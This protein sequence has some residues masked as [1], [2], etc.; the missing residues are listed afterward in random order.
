MDYFDSELQGQIV[1]AGLVV[2]TGA[3]FLLRAV[4]FLRRES[5]GDR[6]LYPDSWKEDQRRTFE[7]IRSVIGLSLVPLWGAYLS[8]TPLTPRSWRFE[9]TLLM[10]MLLAS[11]AWTLLLAPRNS[12]Q[13]DA[14]PRSFFRMIAF[15]V[16]CCGTA[17]AAIGWMLTEVSARPSIHIIPPGVYAAGGMAPAHTDTGISDLATHI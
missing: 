10:L 2:L 7:Q 12:K 3:V 8:L 11:Y 5:V 4:I 9:L 1:L 15:A 17:F 6:P 14:F 16:L 13:L